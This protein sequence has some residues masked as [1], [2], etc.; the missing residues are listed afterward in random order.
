PAVEPAPAPAPSPPPTEAVAAAAPPL[1]RARTDLPNAADKPTLP[2]VI[3]IV[4]APDDPGIDDE[5][6]SAEFA[7]STAPV[8]GQAGGWRGF[9]SRLGG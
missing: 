9:L 7:E 2:A 5:P 1:F 6:E 3:P 4:R 8:P